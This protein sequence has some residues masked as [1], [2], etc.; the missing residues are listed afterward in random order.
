MSKRPDFCSYC[1]KRL[2]VQHVGLVEVTDA[3]GKPVTVNR[4][5]LLCPDW[6]G[7]EYSPHSVIVLDEKVT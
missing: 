7:D 5:S 2:V 4:I 6:N 3:A 1:G